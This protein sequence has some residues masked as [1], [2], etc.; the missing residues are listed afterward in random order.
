MLPDG[1]VVFVESYRSQLSVVE[2]GWGR[3]GYAY[4][5]GAP[6]SCVLGSDGAIYVCQN[7]GTVGP[8]RAAEMTKASIQ[9]FDHEGA[10]AEII[11]TEIEGIALNGPNDLVFGAERLA[12]LHRSGHLSTGR[13]GAQLHLRHRPDWHGAMS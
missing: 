11:I 3:A 5:A 2:P 6:N 4:T 10:A 8:W 12:V 1:R 9:R 13:S 7:G